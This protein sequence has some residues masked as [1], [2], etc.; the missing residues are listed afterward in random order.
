MGKAKP[1]KVCDGGGVG[2]AE[3]AEREMLRGKSEKK[4]GLAVEK[5]GVGATVAVAEAERERERE[6]K[7]E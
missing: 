4:R 3:A 6:R 5:E 1:T 7:S 2:R